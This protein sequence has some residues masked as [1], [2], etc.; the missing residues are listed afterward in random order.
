MLTGQSMR[1]AVVQLHSGPDVAANLAAADV[2]VR[3][4]AADGA[5]LVVL[6][7]PANRRPSEV[8]A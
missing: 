6:P 7:V 8:Y 4:A 3:A 1:A 2:H 5:T